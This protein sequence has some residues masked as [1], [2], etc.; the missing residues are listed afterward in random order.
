MPF[1]YPMSLIQQSTIPYRISAAEPLGHSRNER[2]V[3][4]ITQKCQRTFNKAAPID[5]LP[6]AS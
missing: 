1:E 4:N 2:K 5:Q 6:H 3:V